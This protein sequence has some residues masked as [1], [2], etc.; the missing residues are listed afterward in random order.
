MT[1]SP[2]NITLGQLLSVAAIPFV[3]LGALRLLGIA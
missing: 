1:H 2:A 3:V